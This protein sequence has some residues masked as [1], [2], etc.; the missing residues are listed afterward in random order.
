M[1]WI[2]DTYSYIYGEKQIHA[3]GCATGKLLNQGGI[4]GRTESTG[5]GC[6]YVI[7]ELLQ[8]DSFCEMADLSHGLKGKR[9]IVQGFGN[10]GYHLARILHQDGAKI[11][12]IVE[13]DAG[14]YSKGGFDPEEVKQHLIEHGTLKNCTLGEE[15][16]T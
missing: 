8:N 11:I 10:V 4:D 15:I 12:G 1:T 7:R 9:V 14:I 16:E 6:Y 2:K 13:K 3:A 5:L